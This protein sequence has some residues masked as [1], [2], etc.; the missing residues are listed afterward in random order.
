MA[1]C[2]SKTLPR[3]APILA[4]SGYN[5][6]QRDHRQ[7]EE[8]AYLCARTIDLRLLAKRGGDKPLNAGDYS[9]ALDSI[10]ASRGKPTRRLVTPA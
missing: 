10:T 2:P 6:K 4:R 3:A 8:L 7:S 9:T 5:R 1:L